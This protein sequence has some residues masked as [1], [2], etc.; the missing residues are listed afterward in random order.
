[1]INKTKFQSRYRGSAMLKTS[2]LTHARTPRFCE[3]RGI[4]PEGTRAVI[5]QELREKQGDS[6]KEKIKLFVLTMLNFIS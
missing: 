2:P 3:T 4:R 1:M 5:S 6:Q